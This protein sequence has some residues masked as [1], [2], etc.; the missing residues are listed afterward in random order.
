MDMTELSEDYRRIADTLRYLCDH[1]AEQPDLH[2]LAGRSGLSAS[3]F[4]RVFTRWAGISPKRFL[5]HLTVE[6]AKRVLERSE[7]VLDAA[8]ES[9]LSGPGRLHDLFVACEGASPGEYREH[10]AGVVISWGVHPSPLG[11]CFLA[12]TSRGI[13]GLTFGAAAD[14]DPPPRIL[15]KWRGARWIRDQ[16][17]TSS[18]L[19]EIFQSW[20]NPPLER[21]ALHVRGTNFQISVWRALLRIPPG[22]LASYGRVARLA[23]RPAAV[24]AA[25]QAVGSNPVAY[26]IPCHRVIRNLGELGGYRWGLERK[27]ALLGAEL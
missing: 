2:A 19:E 17:L 22:S 24:R 13:C 26:L 20:P 27:T 4:Q 7:S 9:G 23:Q 3:Y 8:L 5:Q 14:G 10:G 16:E 15:E 25:A 11:S 1:F 6:H 18:S 12:A 21:P